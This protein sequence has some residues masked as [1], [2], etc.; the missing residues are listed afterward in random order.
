MSITINDE[1]RE[2]ALH[3][4]MMDCDN[5]D[6]RFYI[7]WEVMA[8]LYDLLKYGSGNIPLSGNTH[9]GPVLN[10]G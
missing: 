4:L 3:H 7:D 2:W 9:S 1:D 10:G 5:P 6:D 8:H